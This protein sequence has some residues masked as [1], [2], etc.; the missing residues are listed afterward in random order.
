ML[1][2]ID[3][4]LVGVILA[5]AICAKPRI[6]MESNSRNAILS[7]FLGLVILPTAACDKPAKPP[8]KELPSP[9]VHAADMCS[10]TRFSDFNNLRQ[11]DH[12]SADPIINAAWV[13]GATAVEKRR[14]IF[15]EDYCSFEVL[16]S[17][18]Q[19]RCFHF[20][21]K[22]LVTG[23]AVQLCIN[24]DQKVSRVYLDE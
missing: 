13:A 8:S 12:D 11:I 19:E 23:G 14:D 3:I 22:K 18:N 10:A 7:A 16:A 17:A 5:G 2:S 9:K 1:W 4:S 24:R 15:I 20:Y 6:M 21:T